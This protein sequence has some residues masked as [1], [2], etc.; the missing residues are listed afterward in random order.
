VVIIVLVVHGDDFFS[1]G[2]RVDIEWLTM[3]LCSCFET[4]VKAIV[5]PG[6]DKTGEF[7]HRRIS[8]IQGTGFE[9]QPDGRHVLQVAKELGIEDAS[10][11]P[12]PWVM[13]ANRNPEALEPLG[14][15]GKQSYMSG[16]G[17]MIY[18]STDRTDLQ[19]PARALAQTLSAPTELCMQRLRRL[20]RYCLGTLH[21]V[22]RFYYQRNPRYLDIFADSDWA[23]EERD[24]KSVS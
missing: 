8:W 13:G 12:T 15:A 2:R 11:V 16:T 5:G 4:K 1:E 24:R 18:Y 19:W 22:L 3:I 9:Y 17:S 20:V 21:Y 10:S 14:A 23:G 6:A 7:L